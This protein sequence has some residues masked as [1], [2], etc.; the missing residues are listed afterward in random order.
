MKKT[1]YSL[2][3]IFFP[4]IGWSQ[5]SLGVYSLQERI[6]DTFFFSRSL[7]VRIFPSDSV[8]YS[9]DGTS[10]DSAS[11]AY[12][13]PILISRSCGL[14][15]IS[16]KKN[17]LNNNAAYTF[18]RIPHIEWVSSSALYDSVYGKSTLLSLFDS[19]PHNPIR[20]FGDS[21]LLKI[22]LGTSVNISKIIVK[23]AFDNQQI[24]IDFAV[25]TDPLEKIHYQSLKKLV[26]DSE[27]HYIYNKNTEARWVYILCYNIC[28]NEQ[29]TKQG[30]LIDQIQIIIE[31]VSSRL[32]N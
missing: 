7:E 6:K 4:L 11:G 5:E 19:I 22:S 13:R 1:I 2:I 9:F 25:S 14:R 23:T 30:V 10:P 8:Y 27:I 16:H 18:R 15:A 12:K 17:V 24:K 21:V 20:F 3:I 29:N 26:I 32:M 31:P 28:T